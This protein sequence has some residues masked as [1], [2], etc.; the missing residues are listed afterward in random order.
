M[1]IHPRSS[2]GSRQRHVD[3]SP[4]IVV[5]DGGWEGVVRCSALSKM[6]GFVNRYVS[7]GQ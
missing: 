1:N 7:S 4:R 5:L 3:T 2:D 6:A